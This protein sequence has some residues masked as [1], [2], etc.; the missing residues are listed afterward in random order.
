MKCNGHYIWRR[1]QIGKSAGSEKVVQIKSEAIHLIL[2][3]TRSSNQSGFVRAIYAALYRERK[4][5]HRIIR[6]HMDD[7]KNIDIQKLNKIEAIEILCT[8]EPES[9][10]NLITLDDIRAVLRI[11]RRTPLEKKK[12][13]ENIRE[14]E[15]DTQ[16]EMAESLGTSLEFNKNK[17]S[18]DEYTERMELYFIMK[19]IT[20]DNLKVAHLL[21]MAGA[22]TYRLIRELT[23]PDKPKDKKY[24]DI[25]KL[26]ENHLCPKKSAKVERSLFRKTY[27]RSGE[28]VADFVARLREKSIKCDFGTTLKDNLCEQIAAGIQDHDTKIALYSET[29]LTYEKAMEIATAREAAVKNAAAT[30]RPQ[31]NQP[32]NHMRDQQRSS[33]S[34]SKYNKNANEKKIKRC[35]CCG[36]VNDH[37]TRDCKYRDK[38]CNYCKKVGHLEKA[39]INK[40]GKNNIFNSN[41]KSHNNDKK[42]QLLQNDSESEAETSDNDSDFHMIDFKRMPTSSNMNKIVAEPLSEKIFVQDVLIGMEID[43]GT[44]VSA[45]SEFD[46]K[47]FFPNLKLKKC[48]LMLTCYGGIPLQPI[49]KLNSLKVTW[50]D[51]TKTLDLYIMKGKGPILLG[52]Q[53]L[54]AFDLWPIKLFPEVQNHKVLSICSEDIRQ[55]MLEKF[56]ILFSNTQGT[57]KGRKI[58]LVFKE[59]VKPVQMKPHH[60]P[61]AL[62]SKISDEIKRLVKLG[63]LEPVKCSAWAT[64]IIP[65][66]KKNGEVRICGNFKLTVNPQLIIKRHPIPLK[67]KIFNTLQVGHKW[68]Q[69]DLKHAFMQFELDD[70]SKDALT[71]ITHEGLH[72]YT[73][74]G[75]GV[76]SSPAEC[77]DIL[78][79]ILN[80]VP[81][82]EIYI[83]NIYCTGRTE[84]EH[85]DIL[86]EI[87]SRLEK[88]GLRVNLLKCDF[89]KNEIEILGFKISEKGLHASP[90]KIEAIEKAPTPTNVKELEAFLGLVNFYERFLQDRADY[91][92]PLYELVK[93]KK[94]L[95]TDKCQK[96]FDWVKEQIISD[97]ILTLYDPN[98]QLIL[99]CDASDIGL[100]AILSHRFH[101]GSERPIAFASKII[102]KNE[103]HRAIIDKEAGA[104][105]FGFKKFYQYIYGNEI[106]L[107]TDH[108][109]LKFI[110]GNKNM[111]TMIHSRLQRWAY[112]LSG[113][114]YT[115]EVIKS[116]SN[117]NCDALSRL[118]IKDK[119]H[120]FENEYT[121]INYIQNN[122]SII[123]FKTV[124]T[125]TSNDKTLRK[126]VHYVRNEW[127]KTADLSRIENNFFKKRHE[128]EIEN[129][130]L[131]W[132]YRIVI[133]ESLR[134]DILKELHSSHMGVVKMKQLA[135]NYFWWPYLDEDI[136]NLANS[137]KICLE[138]RPEPTKT[139]LTPWQWPSTPW[140]RIH[141]DFM[142][143]FHNCMFLIVVDAHSKWTEVINMKKD[144][145]AH[146]LIK[147]LDEIFSR[148]G[149]P[150]HLVSDNGPQLSSDEFRKFLK[151]YKIKHTFSPP[152]YPATN[153]AAENFVKTVKTKVDKMIKD[154]YPLDS[155]INRFLIDYRN[156]PHATTNKTPSELMFKREIRTRFD[157][158]RSDIV[159]TVEK[160]QFD[161]KRFKHGN[162]KGTF[163]VNEIIYA[164]DYRKDTSKNSKAV[165]VEQRSP[166]SYNVR[167][168]DGFVTKR[169]KNQIF[170][171]SLGHDLR[172]GEGVN[173]DEPHRRDKNTTLNDEERNIVS[174]KSDKCLNENSKSQPEKSDS[175]KRRYSKRKYEIQGEQPRRSTRIAKL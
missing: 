136:E 6:I 104:I 73:R 127:P 161:Q 83:D 167:F 118:P 124:A 78:E 100:S 94:W 23:L 15:S 110:F 142:G 93:S 160:N 122:C 149:I 2:N 54:A 132:G 133:P 34:G 130:S 125:A 36:S 56:P 46:Q 3:D 77:Q 114:K 19:K 144:T 172:R 22:D 7:L 165:I 14:I 26:V 59:E 10:Y 32:V 51:N 138:N 145:T 85:I 33:P 50:R 103:R 67:E 174:E 148:Y 164:K 117:G 60:A 12:Q 29:D 69:I 76:A 63:N 159:G 131:T 170:Q 156:T 58:H 116:K 92:W 40:H 62:T 154:G 18:W 86:T 24:D 106:I 120:V 137:C 147:V 128:L 47:K 31:H 107:K 89:F 115:I 153:G 13:K 11:I 1:G 4:P 143:P 38:T 57:Y 139:S 99:A 155:A 169:H 87:F 84:Q 121:C 151:M 16:Y 37:Y 88:A 152:Y 173:C 72:R 102:P 111:S 82:T 53:W 126:I 70:E 75:E 20:E 175:V 48:D 158:L 119:T 129:G 123:D 98:V 95:W 5:W 140:S 25:I 90:S 66:L 68:S 35:Y 113:Y 101:D 8:F 81:H 171:T 96:G 17:D 163:S 52:R 41:K 43:T 30:S 91:I 141:I 97:K 79:E 109:P 64:P 166:V 45:I 21:T 150:K 168:D 39:C 27:Q 74:L 44:Y 112:F 135:R 28:S 61:F 9:I 71:I 55:K 105:I 42:V 49:G 108:E 65:V 162:R 146:K 80:G 157:L 134:K